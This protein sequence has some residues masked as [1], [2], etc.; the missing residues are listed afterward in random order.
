MTETFDLAVIGSGPGGYRAA[1]LGALRGLDVAII[2]GGDWGGCCLNRGCVPKK[3]WYHTARLVAAQRHFSGRGIQGSLHAS[4]DRAWVHQEAVVDTVRR[5]YLDYMKHLKIAAIEGTARF[6]DAGT[7]EIAGRHADPRRISAR[8]TIIATGAT[9]FI[10]APFE[11]VEGK[12]LT[13]DMLFDTPPPDGKRVAVIGSGVVATE[14]AF[15]FSMLGKDV[16][17]LSR[18]VALRRIPFSPQAMGALRTAFEEHGI[19]HRTGVHFESVDTSGDGVV[20]NL[21]GGEQV[22]ADWICLGTGRIPNTEGL[23]PGAA[24]VRLD[25]E[26][27]VK[28]NAY[29]QTDADNIYAIGDVAGPWMTANHALSDA[30]IAVDNII[31]GNTRTQDPLQV[32][33]V[34]YSAVEM[35]RLGMDED[36][37]EDRELEPAVGFAAFETSPCALGQD[38]TAGFVRLVADMDTGALLG[39]EVIGGDAG[40]LIHLL[41]LAP[42]RDTA[43][44][45]IAKGVFNHPAR[46][47]EILNATE[48]LAIK[49][50]LGDTVF[51]KF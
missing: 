31:T 39:G 48:T 4:M 27:F 25:E 14:F 22:E 13:S 7:L 15:I 2:E 5:S 34:V 3:D 17:W 12:V 18:S 11:T 20:L 36:M 26:G 45:W 33:V 41:S 35:A 49:W 38:D 19:D 6:I 16:I 30:T 28:R 40:E 43:L 44:N 8:H 37:A 51:G 24:G 29:L 21:G 10:P 1:V 23:D 46:A 50:G 9:P 32:P 47:E 42:D